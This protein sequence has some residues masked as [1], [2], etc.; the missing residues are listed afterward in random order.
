[1]RRS[2]AR[3]AYR[4]FAG[5][6]DTVTIRWVKCLPGAKPLPFP[7]SINA[8]S[9]WDS[10]L[11][12]PQ[13]PIGEAVKWGTPTKDDFTHHAPGQHWCG[14]PEW[15]LTGIPP[16][17]R[18]DAPCDCQLQPGK[19]ITWLQDGGDLLQLQGGCIETLQ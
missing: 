6:D 9:I 16:E 15:F 3:Q 10:N 19:C 8:A 4:I 13:Q 14:E 5:S 11:W 2:G 18:H 12:T 17:H 7:C 1:M